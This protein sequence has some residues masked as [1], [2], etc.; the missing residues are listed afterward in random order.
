MIRDRVYTSDD[1]T[2][3]HS[4][5]PSS[6]PKI[7][8]SAKLRPSSVPQT[9]SPGISVPNNDGTRESPENFKTIWIVFSIAG[10]FL[11]RWVSSLMV[12][13]VWVATSQISSLFQHPWALPG[14]RGPAHVIPGSG[15][16]VGRAPAG[17]PAY[18]AQLNHGNL[19]ACSMRLHR[20]WSFIKRTALSSTI[21]S[22]ALITS[23]TMPWIC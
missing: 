9:R 19:K 3:R 2:E 22:P 5:S 10:Y 17:G 13:Y 6:P 8:R 11:Y 14:P 7:R 18:H 20:P 16:D 12:T 21:P 15:T 4:R 1:K 23:T